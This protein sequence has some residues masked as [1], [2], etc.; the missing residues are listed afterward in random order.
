MDL[1]TDFGFKT[2]MSKDENA[3]L[4]IN[5]ILKSEEEVVRIEQVRVLD[6]RA[7]SAPNSPIVPEEAVSSRTRSQT[8][9]EL[10]QL[11]TEIQGNT[12]NMKK[13][14]LDFLC[15]TKDGRLINVE[16]QRAEQ[17]HIADRYLYHFSRIVS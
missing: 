9:I 6:D 5:A 12:I 15:R 2:L 13:V 17:K 11:P 8:V 7:A 14:V 1:K 16:M 3:L 4:L 10:Q